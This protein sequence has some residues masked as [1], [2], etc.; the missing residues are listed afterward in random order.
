LYS[1]A[2]VASGKADPEPE[3]VEEFRTLEVALV[4]LL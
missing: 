3:L 2:A 1:E 4:E